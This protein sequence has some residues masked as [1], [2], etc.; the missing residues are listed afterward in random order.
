MALGVERLWSF[1]GATLTDQRRSLLSTRLI[2]L[3]QV[4]MNAHLLEGAEQTVFGLQ[5]LLG[6]LNSDAAFAS[7]F[8]ELEQIDEAEQLAVKQS[9]MQDK[10]QPVD[11]GSEPDDDVA[12]VQ[13]SE[14]QEE[15]DLFSD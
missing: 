13:N 11:L 4:K 8:E 5:E 2:Q 9:S 14:E 1:A 6:E 10:E 7:I 15:V 12:G 3:L